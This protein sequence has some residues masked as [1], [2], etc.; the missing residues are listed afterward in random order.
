MDYNL[1][2]GVGMVLAN[3]IMDLVK[4]CEA[5]ILILTTIKIIYG[6]TFKIMTPYGLKSIKVIHHI[7]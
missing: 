4:R 7:K 6:V 3:Y 1:G 5:K 2:L